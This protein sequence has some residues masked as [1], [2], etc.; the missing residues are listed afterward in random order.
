M[1]DVL[2]AFRLAGRAAIVTGAASGI[3]AAIAE[4]LA[5]A[6][7]R[8]VVADVDREGAEAVA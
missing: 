7:A 4:V 5:A 2:E 1:S 6:G 8:V 3:G